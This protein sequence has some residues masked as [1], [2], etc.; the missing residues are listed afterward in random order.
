[1][2][3]TLRDIKLVLWA[4]VWNIENGKGSP[5]KELLQ[6]GQ[7]TIWVKALHWWATRCK[8]VCTQHKFPGPEDLGE[9]G[10]WVSHCMSLCSQRWYNLHIVHSVCPVF[11]FMVISSTVS[12]TWFNSSASIFKVH[13]WNVWFSAMLPAKRHWLASTWLRSPN[14]LIGYCPEGWVIQHMAGQ[15]VRAV[16]R[17]ESCSGYQFLVSILLFQEFISMQFWQEYCFHFLHVLAMGQACE[18]KKKLKS[19]IILI[20]WSSWSSHCCGDI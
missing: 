8:V 3:V 15:T 14:S 17:A 4:S 18:T 9:L 16:G 5:S 20:T 10:N 12:M 7:I 1:M 13:I 11:C 6:S 2:K 19:E